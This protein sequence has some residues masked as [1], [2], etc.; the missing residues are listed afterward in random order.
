[1]PI[2]CRPMFVVT[3]GACLVL[4]ACGGSTEGETTA[5]TPANKPVAPKTAD[6]PPDMVAAVSASPAATIGLHFALK[7]APVVNQPLPV[8]IAI[9]PHREFT[10][11]RAHFEAHDGLAIT[12]G[13]ALEPVTL[14]V[15]EKA[16]SHQLVILPNQEG[17]F[18]VTASI[19]TE[20]PDGT[21]TRIFSIPVIVAP[22]T[23]PEPAKTGAK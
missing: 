5:P 21:I 17:V 11:V 16:I 4:T 7:A 10:A 2:N 1:M 20:G 12:T 13:D 18:M 8:D 14:V 9:V 22:A 3:L 19:D 6:L 15:P 23:N